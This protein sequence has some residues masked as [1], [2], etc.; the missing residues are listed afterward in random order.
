MCAMA[1]KAYVL[2]IRG[3]RGTASS[4]G[5]RTLRYG[6]NTTCL[7]VAL[8]PNRRVILDCGS[9]LRSLHEDLPPDPQ[10]EGY[11]FHVFLT[12]YHWDHV[13]GLAS[14]RPVYDWRSTFT[15]HGFTREGTDVQAALE[16]VVRP[17]WFPVSLADTASVKTYVE[18]DHE[19]LDVEGL[20]VA[21]VLLHHPQGIAGYR[22]D[23]GGRSVV[24]ATDTERGDLE[25]DAALLTIA[26]G[27]DVL[28][29]DAQFTPEEYEAKYSG[30]GHSTWEHA[31]AVAREAGVKRLI[32]C[33]H[34]PD[35]SDDEVDRIVE[36]AREEFPGV[37]AAREG[38]NILL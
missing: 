18:L 12:H 38:M 5:S 19:T 15:F 33:H 20:Q 37:E 10:P 8:T 4:P 26:R 35:R 13:E 29:H 17:P 7:E 21:P 25:S 14:F 28:I 16:G 6:G 23:H 31:V 24:F 1:G 30:W 11:H 27:A 2:T 3:A 32:L 22:L 34:D 9:G 36:A